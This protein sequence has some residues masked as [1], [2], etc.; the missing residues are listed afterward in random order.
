M[1]VLE[2]FHFYGFCRKNEEPTSGLEPLTCSLRVR[3]RALLGFARVCKSRI[4]K[5]LSLLRVAT[6]CTV[7]RPRWCQSGVNITL[8][9][10][11]HVLPRLIH[12]GPIEPLFP[13]RPDGARTTSCPTFVDIAKANVYGSAGTVRILHCTLPCSGAS[14]STKSPLSS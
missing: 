2:T 5:W 3:K 13:Y 1:I 4:F 11:W 6:R 7:L 8:A 12:S 9:S 14:F 10:E